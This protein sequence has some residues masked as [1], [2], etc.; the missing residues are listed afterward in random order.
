M[1]TFLNAAIPT[2]REIINMI[3]PNPFIFTAHIL[4]FLLLILFV[5]K[6]IWKPTKVYLQKRKNFIQ[7]NLQKS[8]N[9]RIEAEKQKELAIQSLLESK[10]IAAE[11]INKAETEAQVLKKQVEQQAH[12]KIKELETKAAIITAK[13]EKDLQ[14]Q[15][16]AK[17]IALAV[18]ISQVFLN[19]KIDAKT[20]SKLLDQ[21]LNDLKKTN[22]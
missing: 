10:N 17:V 3:F 4:A 21:I 5:I 11:I 9:L 16:D 12:D 2:Q 8:E 19:H 22:L 20:N 13:K 6:L 14:A 7:D 1:S 18:E 15:N